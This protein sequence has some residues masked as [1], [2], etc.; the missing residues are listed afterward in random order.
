MKIDKSESSDLIISVKGL[1]KH[2]NGNHILKGIDFQVKTGE[3]ISIIG[4]SGCG[5][6]TFLRCLN[7]LEIL[8]AGRMRIAGVNI[9]RGL[10]KYK[11]SENRFSKFTNI[12]RKKKRPELRDD[13]LD[14]D[15][16]LKLH[17]LR[18]RVG[19]LFQS[20]N[21]FPHLTVLQNVTLAP[22][23]VKK[24]TKEQATLRAVQILEKVGLEQFIERHPHE[25]SGGQA[26]RVAI[27]R[28]LAMSP[29]VMLYDEPTSALDPELVEEVTTVMRNLNKEGMTQVVVTHQ[30][31][32]AESA[33]DR[34]IYMEDGQ[35]IEEGPPDVIFSN[36]KDER[37][38]NYL[39]ILNE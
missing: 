24:E 28:A 14:E 3:L 7:C 6:T 8:D 37:T 33:S 15:F 35:I 19:M 38:R 13:T 39:K 20:F 25:L 4:R 26:Q 29:Q 9:S 5:K 17:T 11:K 23:I 30:M 21:L 31:N 1:H 32:F 18:T 27:A 10:D 36:P 34:V 22:M 2:F 12:G 16:Q